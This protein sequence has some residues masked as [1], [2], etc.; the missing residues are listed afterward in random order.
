MKD[1]NLIQVEKPVLTEELNFIRKTRVFSFVFLILYCLAIAGVFS[2]WSLLKSSQENTAKKIQLSEQKIA[3]YKQTESLY[4]FVKRNLSALIPV[5]ASHEVDFEQTLL[6]FKSLVPT[7]VLFNKVIFSDEG[8]L[9]ISGTAENAF[10]LSNFLETL[11]DPDKTNFAD[12]IELSSVGKG[13]DIYS[14]E[15]KINAKH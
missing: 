2:Y 4:A 12:D 14:F 7:G 8:S 9:V 13:T 5:F 10:V 3:N 6:S 11:S 15:L 1:V